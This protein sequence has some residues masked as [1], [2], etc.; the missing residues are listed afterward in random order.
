MRFRCRAG[1]VALASVALVALSGVPASAKGA[2]GPRYT[3]CAS[4]CAY[5]TIQGAINDPVGPATIMIAPGNYIEDVHVTRPVTLDGAG[6]S[7]VVYPSD[8]NPAPAGCTG[9]LCGGSATTMMLVGADN[10]TIENMTLE[11]ANPA[12]AASGVSVGG[13]AVNARNGIIE[14]FTAGTFQNLTVSA[15]TV[16]DVY[17]RGIEAVAAGS[18]ETFNFTH[19]TVSNVQGDPNR[20]VA[21]FNSRGSGTIANNTVSLSSDAINANWSH[22]TDFV[23]NVVSGSASGIHTDNNGGEGGTA[24]LISGNTVRNC[25]IDGYGIW[26]FAPY[27]SAAVTNNAVSGC[28]VGLAAFGSQV[29]GQGPTFAGNVVTGNGAATTDPTGTYGAYLTTDLLGYGDATLTVRLTG[30]TF[31]K[32][33]T[34][35]YV[36]DPGASTAVTAAVDAHGNN[37]FTGNGTGVHGAQSSLSPALNATND[38]WGCASGPNSPHCDTAIGNVSYSPWLTK[39]PTF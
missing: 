39:P 6:P 24:D 36:T 27:V 10:V 21:V 4:G 13:V 20:S 3:V 38:W 28:Y 2:G 1:G 22:G 33:T 8:S 5:T 23:G 9:S 34:G 32:F 29:S 30:N 19:N 12:L 14:D 26:V 18:G 11:G 37:T 7:T 31:E 25:T 35:L 15:V 17:L 16:Q